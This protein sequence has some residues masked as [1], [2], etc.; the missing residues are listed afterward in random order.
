MKYKI[1]LSPKD[2]GERQDP[3]FHLGE[4]YE[5]A[6]GNGWECRLSNCG[7][8]RMSVEQ[9]GYLI[10]DDEVLEIYDTDKKLCDAIDDGTI[11]L[12]NNSWWELEFFK[13][14]DKGRDFID[15]GLF[16][17]SVVDTPGDAI[18]LFKYYMDDKQ[19]VK[20]LK[21]ELACRQ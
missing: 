17:D 19:F 11:N 6:T 7:E 12:V 4:S 9:G 1:T 21:G 3:M 18:E 15:M 16:T 8:Q 13:V 14:S 10:F 20:D 5:L 2:F